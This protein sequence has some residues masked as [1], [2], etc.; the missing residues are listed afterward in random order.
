MEIPICKFIYRNKNPEIPH[1]NPNI[2]FPTE[3]K[4]KKFI[5]KNKNLEIHIE[6]TI[7]KFIY[8]EIIIQKF[9]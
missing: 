2:K 5:Y 4:I 3:I 9:L 7:K 8:I 1:G 6:I